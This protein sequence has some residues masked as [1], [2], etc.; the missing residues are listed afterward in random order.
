MSAIFTIFIL[1]SQSPLLSTMASVVDGINSCSSVSPKACKTC[2]YQLPVPGMYRS[3]I[4]TYEVAHESRSRASLKDIYGFFIRARCPCATT[5]NYTRFHQPQILVKAL[6]L[7]YCMC[8][9]SI[10]AARYFNYHLEIRQKL[11]VYT[12]IFSL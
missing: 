4:Q 12:Y 11:Q 8:S 10:D 5:Q 1:L 3:T 2:Y 9:A 7:Y 6:I